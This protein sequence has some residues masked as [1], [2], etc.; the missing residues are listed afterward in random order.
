MKYQQGNFDEFFK[1]IHKDYLG[2]TNSEPIPTTKSEW[3][4]SAEKYSKTRKIVDVNLSLARMRITGD[5]AVVYYYL[6]Y[7]VTHEK[8]SVPVLFHVKGKETDYFVKEGGKWYLI[9]QSVNRKMV[10]D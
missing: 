7:Q 9:G 2:W 1:H 8:Q 3:R 6:D 5:V 10:K 4:K